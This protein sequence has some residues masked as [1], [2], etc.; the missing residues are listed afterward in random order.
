MTEI[1]RETVE[2]WLAAYDENPYEPPG[3]K[4]SLF[5]VLARSWLARDEAATEGHRNTQA[6]I[7]NHDRVLGLLLAADRRLA[8]ARA[9]CESWIEDS[10]SSAAASAILAAMDKET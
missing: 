10:M 7:D 9:E 1:T 4:W 6:A 2:R 3:D 5:S 8:A